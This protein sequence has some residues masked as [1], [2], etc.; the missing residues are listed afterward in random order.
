MVGRDTASRRGPA[1][2]ASRPEGLG[3]QA[4]M[5]R[6]SS[7]V[8]MLVELADTLVEDFDVVELLTGAGRPLR[9][10]ARRVRSRSDAGLPRR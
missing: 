4:E 8:Q 9:E 7:V 10:A 6:E 5:T 3:G 1:T 2:S